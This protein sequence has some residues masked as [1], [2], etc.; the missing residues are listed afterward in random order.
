M[1]GGKYGHEWYDDPSKNHPVATLFLRV[2]Y[3]LRDHVTH[4]GE[5]RK[6]V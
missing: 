3:L 5:T 1:E 2:T 4:Q 6:N